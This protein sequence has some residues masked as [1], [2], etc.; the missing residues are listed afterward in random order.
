MKT[1]EIKN[2]SEDFE[3]S[4]EQIEALLMKSR[5]ADTVVDETTLVFEALCHSIFAQQE[6]AVITV[7]GRELLGYVTIRLSYEGR[8]FIPE[9]DADG[10]LSPE[11]RVLRAYAEKFD[12]RYHSGYNRILITVRR[13]P[14]S[15][16]LPCLFGML[17]AIA[18]CIPIRFLAGAETAHWA[19]VILEWRYI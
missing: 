3:R 5:S 11:G 4:R 15:S 6:D 10:E 8:M 9:S 13:G 2:L 17:L 18:I 7:S 12:C 16:T 1:T 14:L 19:R